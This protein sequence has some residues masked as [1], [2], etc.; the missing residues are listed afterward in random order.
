MEYLSA[1]ADII[2]WLF[3]VYQ[4][5]AATREQCQQMWHQGYVVYPLTEQQ[6]ERAQQCAKLM[7]DD[8]E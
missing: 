6:Q 5:K 2:L 4:D 3:G 7:A 1:I 8:A